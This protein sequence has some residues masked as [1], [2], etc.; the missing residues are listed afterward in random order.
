MSREAD[1]LFCRIVNGEISSDV[2]LETDHTLAFR[3]LNPQAPTHV[4]VVPKN[5]HNDLAALALHDPVSFTAVGRTVGEVAIVEQLDDGYRVVFNT[6]RAAQQTV[7]HCHAHVLG[8]RTM[9][10][11]PG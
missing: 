5:H 1:C 9:T 8:G 2:V 7:A 4:L 3:D 10:W 11:P 6:G